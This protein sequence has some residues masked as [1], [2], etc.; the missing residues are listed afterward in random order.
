MEREKTNSF[1]LHYRLFTKSSWTILIEKKRMEEDLRK[2]ES[3]KRNKINR[4][5]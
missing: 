3:E 2:V 1:H 4:E 5:S